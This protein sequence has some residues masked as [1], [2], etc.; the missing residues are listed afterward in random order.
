M[1]LSQNMK[2]SL[3]SSA[4]LLVSQRLSTGFID[5]PVPMR[6]TCQRHA[7]DL[8]K[9]VNS[10][11]SETYLG[12]PVGHKIGCTTPIMQRFLEIHEPCAGEIFQTT[13]QYDHGILK[14]SD[15][16]KLGVECELVVEIGCDITPQ[17]QPYSI[18]AT[19]EAVGAIMAGIEVVDDRYREFRSLGVF[20]LIADNFFNAGCVLGKPIKNWRSLDL[21]TLTGRMHING[22]SVG[23]GSA[24]SVMGNPLNALK[25]LIDSRSS[26]GLGL[27]KGCFVFL[28]S[29]VETKWLKAGDHVSIDVDHLSKVELSILE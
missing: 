21:N 28:G 10:Q 9:E 16:R 22:V 8:Q 4:Q 7:Y 1:Q 14:H 23:H 18:I 24:K 25:W 12:A 5:V 26:R 19:T 29:L 17:Q 11:L 20:S 27:K 6:P 15:F 13:V 3:Q 2:S